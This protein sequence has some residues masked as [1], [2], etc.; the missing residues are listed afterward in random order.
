MVLANLDM[1]KYFTTF[2]LKSGYHRIT[3]AEQDREKTAFL[4]SG[5]KYEFCR[6]PFGLKQVYF[7]ER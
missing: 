4:I 5:G 3:L 1:A 7:K 2:D 6:L